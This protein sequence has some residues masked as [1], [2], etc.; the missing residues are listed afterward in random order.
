M[1]NDRLDRYSLLYAEDDEVTRKGYLHYFETRFKRVY[2]AIDGQEALRLYDEHRPDIL[3]LD[4]NMPFLD[5]LTL[6]ETIRKVDKHVKIIILTA[7][8]DEEKLLRAITLHLIDY[9]KKPVKKRELDAVLLKAVDELTQEEQADAIVRIS[10]EVSWHKET[11][12]LLNDKKEIHLTKNEIILLGLL[13]SKA[14]KYYSFDDI[15]EVFWNEIS[16][17]AVRNI[18]KRLKQKLPSGTLINN[19][20]IGYKLSTL[21]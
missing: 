10:T 13:T 20:G 21:P 5:G 7:H 14:K 3:L 2:T 19:Y 6:V 12:S 16:L 8:L 18:I 17:E 9:L 11:K 1:Q 15:L 4:I